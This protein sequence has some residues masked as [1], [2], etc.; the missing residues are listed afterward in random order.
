VVL[1]GRHSDAS[2]EK[3]S[4]AIESDG[5]PDPAWDD[6]GQ[7]TVIISN[8]APDPSAD[9]SSFP[10]DLEKTVVISPRTGNHGQSGPVIDEDMEATIVQKRS[11]TASPSPDDQEDLDATVVINTRG[12]APNEAA[13]LPGD[14]DL[15]A[16]VVQ[17]SGDRSPNRDSNAAFGS[18][19]DL[20]ATVM[21]RPSVERTSEN[22]PS[23]DDM[24]ETPIQRSSGA[25]QKRG[26]PSA[27]KPSD[28]AKSVAPKPS[29]DSGR[30]KIKSPDG[31]DDIMEQTVIIR[32]DV[33]KK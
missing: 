17:K 20:D 3:K 24:T 28:A 23:D 5:A 29:Q 7:A 30:E 19:D 21:I 13:A 11:Q 14:D 22:Q 31:D 6:D 15:A 8:N 33:K 9:E 1:T 16:T 25:D 18:P 32:S 27:A 10:D 4:Q 26:R 2:S 12:Q